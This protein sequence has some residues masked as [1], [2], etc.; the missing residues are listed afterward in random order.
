MDRFRLGFS[1]PPR[2]DVVCSYQGLIEV[3]LLWPT[4]RS[5][6]YFSV[7]LLTVKPTL[8]SSNSP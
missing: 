7:G 2:P 1:F 6:S 8:I 3:L 4:L 5:G